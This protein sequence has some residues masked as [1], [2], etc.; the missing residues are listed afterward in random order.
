MVNNPLRAVYSYLTP[1]LNSRTVSTASNVQVRSPIHSKSIGGW[2]NYK[3]ML[4]PAIEIL[5]QTDR[6]RDLIS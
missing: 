1:H 4:Q 3:E 6:Y 2:K 5:T